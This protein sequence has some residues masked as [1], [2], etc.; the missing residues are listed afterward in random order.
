[1]ITR[2]VLTACIMLIGLNTNSSGTI[3]KPPPTPNNPDNKP[4]TTLG[5][6]VKVQHVKFAYLVTGQVDT[7]AWVEA[8]DSGAF[9]DTLLAINAI[10]GVDHTSTN[11]ALHR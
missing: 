5:K 7:I 1:M 8:T 11:V 9:L 2:E 4:T 10:S 3:K 6:I